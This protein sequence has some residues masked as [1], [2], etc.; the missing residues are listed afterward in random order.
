[1]SALSNHEDAINRRQ[2]TERQMGSRW[3]DVV[4]QGI[5][6]DVLDRVVQEEKL[7]AQRLRDLQRINNTAKIRLD[8]IKN[9][10]LQ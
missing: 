2:R 4:Y 6:R 7:Y 3:N 8:V 5:K 10:R 1:M 9:A